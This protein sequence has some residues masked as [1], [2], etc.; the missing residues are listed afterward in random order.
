[1]VLILFVL[2]ASMTKVVPRYQKD[3]LTLKSKAKIDDVERN[4]RFLISSLPEAFC[5]SFYETM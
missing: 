3:Y 2:M 5:F 4:I 1:M